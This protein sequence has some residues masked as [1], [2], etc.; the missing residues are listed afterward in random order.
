MAALHERRTRLLASLYDQYGE[1]ADW[2]PQGGAADQV[3]VRRRTADVEL[4]YGQSETLAASNLFRVR[5]EE[6]AARP[7]PGDRVDLPETDEAFEV[8]AAGRRVHN[9]LEW[10]FEVTEI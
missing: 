10:L 8:I 5:V 9:G 6:V 7:Q 4:A 3:T 2:T 1:T